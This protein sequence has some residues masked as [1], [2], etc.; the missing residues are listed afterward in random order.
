MTTINDYIK[1][2]SSPLSSDSKVLSIIL[3][4]GHGKRIKSETSKMLHTIWNKPSITRVT[5]AV[6]EGLDNKNQIIVVGKKATEIMDTL[7]IQEN[8]SYAFQKQQ[9]G[10][11]HA[12]RVALENIHNPQ[13]LNNIETVFI[14]PGDMGL[15]NA[16]E[17]NKIKND[18]FQSDFDM[19]VMSGSY[20]G[21]PYDNYYGRIIKVP[22]K[23]INDNPS[24]HAG[25]VIEIMEFKD[26]LNVDDEK[27]Y[28]ITHRGLDYNFSKI[29]LLKITEFNA[30]VYG[31]KMKP[32][33]ENISNLN[34]DNTQHELYI[35][36]LVSILN[37][38]NYKVGVS[39]AE[40]NTSVIGFNLKSVLK[41]MGS[42]AR[43]RVY[44]KLKDIITIVDE[45]DFFIDDKVIERIMALDEKGKALDIV[46][47]K[48]VRL[49]EGVHI[50]KGVRIDNHTRIEGQV[51]ID[52]HTYI[53]SDCSMNNYTDQKISI[54]KHCQFLNDTVIRG[55]VTVANN[56][57]IES[58]VRITG[59]DEYPATIEK[60]VLIKGITYI[61]GSYVERDVEIEHSLLKRKRVERIVRKDGSIQP[62]RYC[63]PLPIGLDSLVD[64]ED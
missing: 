51:F 58:G 4:A 35:T 11:G 48:G 36:D 21:N 27:G 7:G 57:R 59:S 47:G 19:I 26:V 25:E 39:R 5:D 17:V 18:F 14:F 20:E 43:Q 64:L 29:Q 28:T 50:S 45:E 38:S 34:P 9:K 1:K 3:A 13:I 52:E 8:T 63:L 61:F 24:P 33:L 16:E 6:K 15:I 31:F 32:L 22:P 46:I 30:G 54:G 53:G 62:I 23:D 49:G 42:I 10:T 44:N 56:V 41:T 60:N 55:N 37:K 2:Y 12:V 40:D